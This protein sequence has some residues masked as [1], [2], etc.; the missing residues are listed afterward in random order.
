MSIVGSARAGDGAGAGTGVAG[1]GDT[2]S[3]GAN[4]AT[5]AE[6]SL[7]R[8]WSLL[9]GGMVGL[10]RAGGEVGE[11]ADTRRCQRRF[12]RGGR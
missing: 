10:N 2:L 12:Q 9:R 5:E 11:G 7:L 4:L 8:A 1:A 3:I 6:A